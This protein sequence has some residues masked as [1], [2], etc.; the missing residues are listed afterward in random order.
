M[1]YQ[2]PF[3]MTITVLKLTSYSSWEVVICL[4][5]HNFVICFEK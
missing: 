5:I 2:C 1:L 4:S 3:T